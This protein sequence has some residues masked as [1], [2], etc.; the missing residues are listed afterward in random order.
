MALPQ[1]VNAD[2][3]VLLLNDYFPGLVFI[4][5][6]AGNITVTNYIVQKNGKWTL[7]ID[8]MSKSKDRIFSGLFPDNI[9][10]WNEAEARKKY[11]SADIINFFIDEENDVFS[12]E[13]SKSG[14]ASVNRGKSIPKYFLD[15]L[16]Y[17][18]KPVWQDWD[19]SALVMHRMR[20]RPPNIYE[21]FGYYAHRRYTL[22]GFGHGTSGGDDDALLESGVKMLNDT[23]RKQIPET[24]DWGIERL[25]AFFEIIQETLESVPA[26]GSIYVPTAV[27]VFI[28]QLK[29]KMPNLNKNLRYEEETY[30][31]SDRK[32]INNQLKK[33]QKHA[34]DKEILSELHNV[35][36][37]GTYREKIN[38]LYNIVFSQNIARHFSQRE[39]DTIHGLFLKQHGRVSLDAV[40]GGGEDGDF[41]GHDLVSDDKNISAED[42]LAWSSFFRDEFANE[43]NASALEKFIE[44]IPDHFSHYPFDVDF[45]GNLSISKYSR[46]MLFTTFCSS[47]GI[48]EDNELWK[49]FLVLLERVVDNINKSRVR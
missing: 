7:D 41:T 10:S 22:M 45:D 23:I 4:P 13:F 29:M 9:T 43:I 14:E 39:R 17:A 36:M 35:Q 32:T 48:T 37:N 3:I 40:L 26:D 19:F 47:A 15:E 6:N 12:A 28:N 20:R 2:F 5:K 25:T 44:C 42:R 34:T 18:G 49:F 8:A 21:A 30:G 33:V 38:L 11:G 24:S 46:K 16:D 31:A 1:D 27:D